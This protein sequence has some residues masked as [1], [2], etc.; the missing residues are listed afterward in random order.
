MPGL[1]LSIYTTIYII[2]NQ[3]PE[4][5]L[6]CNLLSQPPTWKP[7]RASILF[8]DFILLF[9]SFMNYYIIYIPISNM[10]H[11]HALTNERDAH[12]NII[13]L[14]SHVSQYYIIVNN[15]SIEHRFFDIINIFTQE[16]H[17]TNAYT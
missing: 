6:I 13:I 5:D 3:P 1:I 4:K 10:F 11:P 2:F 16:H 9:Y 8:I 7:L 17:L 12:F 15:T 14:F